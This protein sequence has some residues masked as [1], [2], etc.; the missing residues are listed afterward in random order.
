M[1]SDR[2]PQE[3]F[4]RRGHRGPAGGAQPAARGGPLSPFRLAT[5]RA[6]LQISCRAKQLGAASPNQAAG[7][8]SHASNAIRNVHKGGAYD[9]AYGSADG[10]E[11]ENSRG[12]GRSV[13]A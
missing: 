10:T 2:R 1:G 9:D 11:A 3:A 6:S 4:F 8:R 12:S 13:H 5:T 7:F